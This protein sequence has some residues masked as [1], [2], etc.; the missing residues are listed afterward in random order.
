MPT[1]LAALT[2][3]LCL[4]AAPA[5]GQPSNSDAVLD[6]TFAKAAQSQSTLRMLLQRFPKGADLHNHAGGSIYSEDTLTWA[7]ANNACYSGAAKALSPGPCREADQ[8]PVSAL[9]DNPELYSDVID[10]FSLRRFNLGVG[11][12]KLS[13]HRRFFGVSRRFTNAGGGPDMGKPGRVLAVVMEQAAR[14]NVLYLELNSGLNASNMSIEASRAIPWSE[15]DMA[16]RLA[17][18][19]PVVSKAVAAG[20]LEADANESG[21]RE[22]NKC[23]TPAPGPGC[24]TTLRYLLSVSRESQ[25]DAVFGQMAFHF[26][27]VRADP[28]FVGIN[29]AQPEDWPVATRDYSLHMRMF[30]FFKQRYP[31]V[32]LTLHA[33]ELTLGLVPPRDL[34]FH[35]REAIEVAGAKRIGHG[36]SI[37]YEDEAE[38]LLAKMAREKIAVEI[39]LTSN[40]VILGVK[41]SEHPMALYMAAGVPLVISTDDEGRTRHDMTYEYMRAVTEQGLSYTQLRRIS[42]DSVTY[43]F[44]Q[45][46]SLWDASGVR[47]AAPCAGLAPTPDRG[48]AAL[49]RASPKAQVQYQLEQALAEYEADLLNPGE[50]FS[51][52]RYPAALRSE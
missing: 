31:E 40:D 9:T 11:D 47:L 43:S 4:T 46:A 13:G 42:R 26:A 27:M 38:E 17:K 14:S 22:L 48:C 25:P 5:L 3:A 16:A 33:G 1:R 15:A 49:L 37:A 7:A 41:G 21:A 28:R 35:I 39:N 18:I 36:V 23:D 44:L 51:V 32:P 29:I 2:I 30:N 45:G 52:D 12:P 19:A 10:A 34:R 6:A 20:K 24:V 50:A 8:I